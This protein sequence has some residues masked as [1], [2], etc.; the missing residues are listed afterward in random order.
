MTITS[1]TMHVDGTVTQND[2][3][4]TLEY[5]QGEVGGYIEA[6]H[7]AK[8]QRLAGVTL[9]INEEG[10]LKGLPI[11]EPATLLWWDLD[12]RFAH[13]DALVGDVVVTGVADQNGETTNIPDHML[14]RL[15][16]E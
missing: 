5:L 9:W 7:G 14:R 4:L 16:G 11:N 10:K 2:T 6:V 8:T 13:Y 15:T 3:P 1:V 12:P